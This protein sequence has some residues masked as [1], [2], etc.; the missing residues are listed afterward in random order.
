MLFQISH[1]LP[2]G[3][4]NDINPGGGDEFLILVER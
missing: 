1:S 4:A 2:K 3:K